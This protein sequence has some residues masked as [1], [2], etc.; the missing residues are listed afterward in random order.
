MRKDILQKLSYEGEDPTPTKL[1]NRPGKGAV[2]GLGGQLVLASKK[3]ELEGIKEEPEEIVK[4]LELHQVKNIYI[5]D[6]KAEED[7]EINRR[8]Y[9]IIGSCFSSRHCWKTGLELKNAFNKNILRAKKQGQHQKKDNITALLNGNKD[10][11]W[12]LVEYKD[13]E[14]SLMTEEQ[15]EAVDLE[16]KW[17]NPVPEEVVERHSRMD[18]DKKRRKNNFDDFE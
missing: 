4:F 13:F 18:N 15:R 2:W 11:E 14:V 5:H 8:R 3:M 6:W 9:S 17:N 1:V 16:W 7:P 12:T 10:D